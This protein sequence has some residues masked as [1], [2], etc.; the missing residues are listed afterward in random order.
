MS[1]THTNNKDFAVSKSLM[2]KNRIICVLY[3]NGDGGVNK[4]GGDESGGRGNCLKTEG[5]FV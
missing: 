5:G 4:L 3:T 1:T 2:T